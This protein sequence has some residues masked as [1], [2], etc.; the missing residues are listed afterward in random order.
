MCVPPVSDTQHSIESIAYMYV[1]IYLVV[2]TCT[3]VC[4][5]TH[6]MT[7]CCAR[8]TP[9]CD[10]FSVCL[11]VCLQCVHVYVINLC[12][13][14]GFQ[15]NICFMFIRI[16]T[17]E[18][19]SSHDGESSSSSA[20]G[21]ELLRSS[22][23]RCAGPTLLYVPPPYAMYYDASRKSRSMRMRISEALWHQ[24]ERTNVRARALQLASV[25]DALA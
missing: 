24:G 15:Q 23:S 9:E 6:L 7:V 12:C 21:N 10:M 11:Y 13:D 5:N 22:A 1:G 25:F 2:C 19:V 17:N 8:M 20:V 4:I 14:D 18:A 3:H 16:Y